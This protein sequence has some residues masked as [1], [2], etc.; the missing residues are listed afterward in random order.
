MKN[1]PEE[2]VIGIDLGGTNVRCGMVNENAVSAIHSKRINNQ[3]S[4]EEVMK[5]IFGLADQ[6]INNIGESH[7]H[8]CSQRSGPGRGDCL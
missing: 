1:N 6:L 2:Y 7:R 3:A 4:V 8:R 5:D